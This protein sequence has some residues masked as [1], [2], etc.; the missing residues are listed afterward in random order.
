MGV[1]VK[2]QGKGSFV[3][4]GTLGI[5]LA[6]GRRALPVPLGHLSHD[7]AEERATPARATVLSGGR[8]PGPGSVPAMVLVPATVPVPVSVS[9]P[10]PVSVTMPVPVSGM[11]PVPATASTAAIIAAV[12]GPGPVPSSVPVPVPGLAP[13][14]GPGGRSFSEEV[15]LPQAYTLLIS[16]AVKGNDNLRLTTGLLRVKDLV[17]NGLVPRGV[18]LLVLVDGLD[19]VSGARPLHEAEVRVGAAQFVL[20]EDEVGLDL[21][22]DGHR[23]ARKHGV[24]IVHLREDLHDV[25]AHGHLHRGVRARRELLCV[26]NVV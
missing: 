21:A 18:V 19:F 15:H 6:L 10:V 25:L 17:D 16:I 2:R 11:A 7:I 3:A 5:V 20:E 1:S 12:P 24:V 23:D 9:V 14:A 26:I 4:R 13:P 22:L 8:V